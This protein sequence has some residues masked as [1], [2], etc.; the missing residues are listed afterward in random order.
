MGDVRTLVELLFGGADAVRQR[1]ARILAEL[2]E[3]DALDDEEVARIER[4]IEDAI[5]RNRALLERGVVTPLRRAAQRMA[6]TLRAGPGAA[7]GLRAE[8]AVA[9][10]AAEGPGT[11]LADVLAAFERRVA[12]LEERVTR[13]ED[14]DA[15]PGSG[16]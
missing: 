1:G 15:P 2:R 13:L 4:A 9:P 12:D 16:D 5:A 10:A 8:R 3:N 6:E 14:R 11:R 7:E